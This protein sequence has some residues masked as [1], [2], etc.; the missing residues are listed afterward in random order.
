MGV[1]E[2]RLW[3]LTLREYNALHAVYLRARGVEVHTTEQWRAKEA[4]E[5]YIREQWVKARS[6]VF[7]AKHA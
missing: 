5:A 1:P 7:G 3:A 4:G 2:S 6:K